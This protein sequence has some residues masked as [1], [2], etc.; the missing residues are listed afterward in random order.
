MYRGFPLDLFMAQCYAN[1]DDLGKGRQMPV[2]YGSR[3]LNFI[4]ISSPLATQI[5]QGEPYTCVVTPSVC[6]CST[7]MLTCKRTFMTWPVCFS[8]WSCICSQERKHEPCCDLLL[9]RGCSQRRGRTR[10]LQ[11]L[12][13]PWVPADILLSQQWLR[14][15]NP[16][17]RAVQ[18]RRHW[19]GALLPF[20]A[21]SYLEIP[22]C[23][24]ERA[25]FFVWFN[26]CSR[27]RLRHAF[28]PCWRQWRVCCVQ[29]HKGG[30]PQGRGWE[31]AL[32]HW[33]N[34]LQVG[35]RCSWEQHYILGLS[36]C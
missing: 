6:K 31:P 7:Y 14:Y 16:H 36:V 19:W 5:P 28:H 18:R 32:S 8:G 10:W 29:C 24:F 22:S 12:C 17:Q 34:D 21:A 23:S 27:A 2:H 25:P 1:A 35:L 26:S 15:F 30:T 20:S 11:L 9:W 3:D 4:T 13:H 33:G